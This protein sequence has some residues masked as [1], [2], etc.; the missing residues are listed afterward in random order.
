MVRDPLSV[1]AGSP[2]TSGRAGWAL[3]RWVTSAKSAA[4]NASREPERYR[5]VHC[6][7]LVDDPGHAVRAVFDFLGLSVTS[8]VED[9]LATMGWERL[10]VVGEE[11]R[12]LLDRLA[13][14]HAPTVGYLVEAPPRVR[15]SLRGAVDVVCYVIGRVAGWV[16]DRVVMRK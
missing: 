8:E 5:I 15:P 4:R 16:G 6:E 2:R 10:R 9:A 11:P 7:W 3:A 13:V 1:L 12:G 14:R